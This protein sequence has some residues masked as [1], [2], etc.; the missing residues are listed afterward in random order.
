MPDAGTEKMQRLLLMQERLLDGKVLYKADCAGEFHVTAK[1]V[2]RD[3]ETLRLFFAERKD[4]REVVYDPQARGYR[5]T[6][7]ASRTLTSSEV[8]AVCK[9]L[10]DSRSMVKEEMFPILDKLVQ[11]CAPA[12]QLKQVETLIANE[13]FHY[14]E[15]HHGQKF[16]QSLWDLGAAVRQHRVVEITYMRM[17]GSHTARTLEP[18]GILFSE[19][20]FYLAAYIQGMDKSRFARPQDAGPTIYRI[21]RIV[22]Q[23]VTD[24]HFPV[25]YADRFQEGEMRKRIQFMYGGPL[26]KIRFAYTG[27]NLESILDKLPTARQTGQDPD[28]RP[29]LEA[30]VYD[31][32][33]FQM[34]LRSQG[35]WIRMIEKF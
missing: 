13:R 35:E 1:T 30:E 14:I 34:W 17:D 33:G 23:R 27:P 5:L 6:R 16:I 20:Y 7:C 12:A 11:N 31:E 18:V 8:L 28:G 22:D 25:I 2:Q 21:D 4:G 24:T 19:Y 26:V 29:I 9:I 10:L 32:Q 3:L 15:P